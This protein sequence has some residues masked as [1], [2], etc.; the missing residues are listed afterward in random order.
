ME[1]MRKYVIEKLAFPLDGIYNYNAKVLTSTDGGKTYWYCG[2]GK[3]C[4][5]EEE[6]Q[7]Y[8][9]DFAANKA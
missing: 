9:N 5:T 6:A 3:F 7:E 8:I 4:K 2:I 1:T